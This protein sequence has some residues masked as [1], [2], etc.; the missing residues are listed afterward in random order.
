[1]LHFVSKVVAIQNSWAINADMK[2]ET[3]Y[4]IQRLKEDFAAKQRKSPRYSL[5][6]YARD[7][8]VHPSTLSLV[9][10]GK[11]A[12][13]LKDSTVIAQK[14]NMGPK[15][16]TYFFES[17]YK[18]RARLDE[19]KISASDERL[20]LDESYFNVIAEWEHYAVLTLFDLT[21]FAPSLKEICR[22]LDL[23]E[24]RA[25]VVVHNLISCGLLKETEKGLEKAQ[26]NVRTTEDVMST[27][28]QKSHIEAMTMG[29]D[30]IK[31][32]DVDMR[33][34]SSVTFAMDPAKM[35]EA[36]AILREFRQKMTALMESGEKTEVFQ[37]AIQ[38]YPLTEN[39]K[40]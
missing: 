29:I 9:L 13:P 10:K 34:F 25:E 7:M 12:L 40:K 2:N 19:I 38:M 28:L 4:Y 30:K 36:K 33:D 20:M 5:R 39:F 23:T 17:L 14:M 32:V 27:A 35:P 31:N 24:T 15:E 37:M 16:R 6:A 22:Q 21:N 26:C 3:P 1:M 18:T 8:S 11:R